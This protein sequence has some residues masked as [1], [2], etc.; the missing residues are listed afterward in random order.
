M[1]VAQLVEWSL[2]APDDQGLNPH[3]VNLTIHSFIGTVEKIF[4]VVKAHFSV[5]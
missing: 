5:S 3:I 1:V 4:R 2:Q